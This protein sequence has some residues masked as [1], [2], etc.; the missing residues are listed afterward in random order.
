MRINCKICDTSFQP[1]SKRNTICSNLECKKIAKRAIFR[2]A[3]SK[4]QKNNREQRRQISDKWIAE[5]LDRVRLN[6]RRS[7]RRLQR[8]RNLAE[9][10]FELEHPSQPKS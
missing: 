4:W 1:R 6:K 2:K 9:A 7:V 10:L 5:N 3:T 8:D